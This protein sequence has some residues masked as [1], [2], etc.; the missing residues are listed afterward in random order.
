MNTKVLLQG[1]GIMFVHSITVRN[2]IE[3]SSCSADAEFLDVSMDFQILEVE[4]WNSK[5]RTEDMEDIG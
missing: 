4:Q 5:T 2:L 1:K 3:L